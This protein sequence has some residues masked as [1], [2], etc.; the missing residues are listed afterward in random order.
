MESQSAEAR[1]KSLFEAVS[2]IA[3]DCETRV[4]RLAMS[5]AEVLASGFTQR[6]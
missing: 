5:Y 4:W 3:P 6:R 1:V 2:S